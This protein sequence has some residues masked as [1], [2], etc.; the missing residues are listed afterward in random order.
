VATDQ[1][2]NDGTEQLYDEFYDRYAK[3]LEAAHRGAYLAVSRNGQTIL[4]TSLREV[5]QQATSIFGPG[6]FV[7]KIGERA[8]GKWR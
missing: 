1:H 7:Y 6:N 5:A 2:A 4:G 3:P 8:V